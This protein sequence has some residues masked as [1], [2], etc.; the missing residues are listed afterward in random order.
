M[1]LEQNLIYIKDIVLGDVNKVENG[2][3]TVDVEGLKAAIMVDDKVKDVK[4]DVAKP[5]EHTRIVPVKDV[6]EP[7]FRV[8][9]RNG[10]PGVTTKYE[11]AGNGA[12][13]I[14]KG[15]TII[16]IGDLVGFQ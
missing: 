9:R 1:R 3:L 11:E 2:V 10:F 5:G 6:I 13:N 12:T 7:R 8:G 14:L 16:T 15:A 4:V